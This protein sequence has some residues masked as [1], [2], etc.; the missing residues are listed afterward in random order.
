[1][2][3]L[4]EAIFHGFRATVFEADSITKSSRRAIERF[5]PPVTAASGLPLIHTMFMNRHPERIVP[6]QLYASYKRKDGRRELKQRR[7]E[8]RQ[9]TPADWVELDGIQELVFDV[10][11]YV[12]PQITPRPTVSRASGLGERIAARAHCYLGVRY[13]L[14]GWYEPRPDKT[15]SQPATLDCGP[16]LREGRGALD[17]S[18]LVNYVYWD[19][20]G[21]RLK[22]GSSCRSGV[23]CLYQ[24][25][26]FEDLG[27]PT[28]ADGRPRATPLAGDLLLRKEKK[29]KDKKEEERAWQHVAIFVGDDH[30]IDAWYTGTVVRKRRYVP[31]DW[32][33]VLRFKGDGACG[34]RTGSGSEFLDEGL[35][36]QPSLWVEVEG[37]EPDATGWRDPHAGERK[38]QL[39]VQPRYLTHAKPT[40]REYTT[41]S[42]HGERPKA[43]VR[44]VTGNASF[45]SRVLRI[46]A[47]DKHFEGLTGLDGLTIGIGDFAAGSDISFLFAARELQPTLFRTIFGAHTDEMMQGTS[48]RGWLS[49]HAS[50][51]NDH[52][53]IAIPWLR[54]GIARLL[55]DQRFYGIQLAF[56]QRDKVAPSLATFSSYGFE[57]EFSLAAMCG[58][59][60][61]MGPGGMR[62]LLRKGK[63]AAEAAGKSG[64]EREIAILRLACDQYAHTG[65]T[66]RNDE[67]EEKRRKASAQAT[68][69][70]GHVFDGG[71]APGDTQHRATRIL[72]TNRAFP[73]RQARTFSGDLGQFA[74]EPGERAPTAPVHELQELEQ[75]L[76][77]QVQLELEE[78]FPV[79]EA[80][81][82]EDDDDIPR[83]LDELDR[84]DQLTEA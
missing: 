72:R 11:R 22:S 63:A 46:I 61:S 41:Y 5:R 23:E 82:D 70:I 77:L 39:D 28:G 57:L 21:C 38:V 12:L 74:L 32:E 54:K 65:G 17:C 25:G 43:E 79:G 76:E 29:T 64:R 15:R 73:L 62:R 13:A 50:R 34:P 7:E 84:L 14:G 18:G 58:M 16:V 80:F 51:L 19:V 20:R 52:G 48:R 4:I 9:L 55:A 67:P 2:R 81:L 31:D 53:L 59:A 26:D 42:P 33:Y 68:A 36:E 69:A 1:M 60:N 37:Q 44:R 45:V 10:L 75:E 27:S 40:V 35:A 24:L 6:G 8:N 66:F 83:P 3:L 30:L 78:E 47:A 71:P 56:W 49:Q